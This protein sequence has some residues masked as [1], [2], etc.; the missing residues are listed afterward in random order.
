MLHRAGTY[1]EKPPNPPIRPPLAVVGVVWIL[2]INSTARGSNNTARA[3]S[4]RPNHDD[5]GP[6]EDGRGARTEDPISLRLPHGY[7]MTAPHTGT[8]RSGPVSTRLG[9]RRPWERGASARVQS[10]HRALG[11]LC[12]SV[13][14]L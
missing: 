12:A 14:A 5:E 11:V 10:V 4:L 13:W 7:G 9:R 8:G 6:T 2:D 1:L 3:R